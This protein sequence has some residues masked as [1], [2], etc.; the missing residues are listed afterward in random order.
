[1]KEPII[2]LSLPFEPVEGTKYLRFDFNKDEDE[3]GFDA[4]VG[5]WVEYQDSISA[6]QSEGK[7]KV[8]RFLQE[9]LDSLS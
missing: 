5:V 1:M 2:S 7:E 8:K 4:T 6:M 3:R 9:I